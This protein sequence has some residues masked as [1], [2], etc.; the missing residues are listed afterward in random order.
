MNRQEYLKS[1]LKPGQKR[2]PRK[3]K[4]KFSKYYRQGGPLFVLNQ[5]Q[6]LNLYIKK[7]NENIKN[8]I[9]N[10]LNTPLGEVTYIPACGID[11]NVLKNKSK[12]LY[13]KACKPNVTVELT[14][15]ST[16]TSE[17]INNCKGYVVR[18]SW[19]SK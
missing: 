18:E 17:E 10:S 5:T 12:E 2:L 8:A 16:T 13:E 15:I 7:D 19:H 6:F 11:F 4:K 14:D 9:N 3:L 1:F